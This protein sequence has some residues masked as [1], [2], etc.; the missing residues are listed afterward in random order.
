MLRLLVLLFVI[1]A[2]PAVSAANDDLVA[3]IAT[4]AKAIEEGDA[5][6]AAAILASPPRRESAEWT[7]FE[8][9][10]SQLQAHKETRLGRLFLAAL[11]STPGATGLPEN[12]K[13]VSVVAVWPLS[14]EF[15]IT[16]RATSAISDGKALLSSIDVTLSGTKAV[17]FASAAP[18]FGASRASSPDPE[19]LDDKR[20]DELIPR[21]AFVVER[22][23]YEDCLNRL[24]TLASGEVVGDAKLKEITKYLSSEAEAKALGDSLAAAKVPSAFWK[25]LADGLSSA[26]IGLRPDSVPLLKGASVA[27]AAKSGDVSTRAS[28]TR[29]TNG[30]VAPGLP[31]VSGRV[32]GGEET[33]TEPD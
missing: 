2:A 5:D 28:A 1:P 15:T 14:D 25:S 29:L 21:D 32:G 16:V 23:G 17:A 13:S 22:N 30:F 11:K 26:A 6:A 33:G 27:V 9:R 7:V 3:S 12:A 8:A 31:A 4:L 18:Y 20:L 10:L 19:L 24:S